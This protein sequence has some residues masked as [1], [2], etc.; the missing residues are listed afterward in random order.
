MYKIRYNKL[1]VLR[2]MHNIDIKTIVYKI[3][4]NTP[5]NIYIYLKYI[6]CFMSFVMRY[7][8]F[9]HCVVY[10]HNNIISYNIR[11]HNITMQYTYVHVHTYHMILSL[12]LYGDARAC[13]CACC[14]GGRLGSRDSGRRSKRLR[15]APTTYLHTYNT[16]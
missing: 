3:I 8:A 12:L 9:C 6:I 7:R 11:S 13:G 14:R 10:V 15:R 1:L 4:H 2:V 16:I 5:Y